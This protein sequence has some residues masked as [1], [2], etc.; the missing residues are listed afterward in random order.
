MKGFGLCIQVGDSKLCAGSAK[1]LSAAVGDAVPVGDI[2]DQVVLAFER[3]M[4]LR[5]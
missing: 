1:Y 5:P 2:D 4:I 3:H